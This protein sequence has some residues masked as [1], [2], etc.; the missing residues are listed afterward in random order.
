MAE[1]NIILINGLLW[2]F[3]DARCAMRTAKKDKK[4]AAACNFAT[5]ETAFLWGLPVSRVCFFA[6]F[7]VADH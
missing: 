2:L 3:G 1:Y 5:V 4:A 7:S 6:A